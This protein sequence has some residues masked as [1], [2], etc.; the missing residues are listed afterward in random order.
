MI[1]LPHHIS[2]QFDQE[3]EDVRNHVLKM[4]G[5]VEMQLELAM[6]ALANGDSQLGE[7]V[8]RD[9]Y[10]VN[11]LEVQID[12]ECSR[13]LARR[14]PTAGDLRLVVAVIKTI[15][16]LERIGDEAEKIG[17]LAA[18]LAST[19]RPANRYREIRHLGR[20]VQLMVHDSLNAFARLDANEAFSVAKRDEEVDDD[21]ESILRQLI[22]F[23]MEDPRT[24][25][26]L[27][28]V[29]WVAR[30]LERIGDH[31][32]NICEYV[33]YLAHGRDVRHIGIREHASLQDVERTLDSGEIDEPAVTR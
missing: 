11:S 18:G 19:Q 2:R 20:H 7:N 27:L 30:A 6:K 8:A 22:T 32:K 1:E 13:I 25:R 17:Y 4:G 15:T 16:D 33:I 29:M 21:Y 10:K 9:D 3:L 26:P 5:L 24:I 28:S 23:M 31:A 14:Q 12:E